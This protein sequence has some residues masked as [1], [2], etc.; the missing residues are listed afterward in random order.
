MYL[1]PMVYGDFAEFLLLADGVTEQQ[2]AEMYSTVCCICISAS[3]QLVLNFYP[4]GRN[5][6]GTQH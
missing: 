3:L 2:N 5:D 1:T 6:D 4:P